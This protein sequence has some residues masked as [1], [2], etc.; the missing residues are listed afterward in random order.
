M[1]AT[2]LPQLALLAGAFTITF[3]APLV[4]AG[5]LGA[6]HWFRWRGRYLAALTALECLA[7]STLRCWQ[8]LP[9]V[10]AGQPYRLAYK[11]SERG[12]RAALPAG[13]ARMEGGSGPA[14]GW[15]RASQL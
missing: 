9:G 2:Y 13:S 12:R 8:W 6:E 3:A 7:Y 1:Q 10:A 5:L 14:A 4:V 15:G 11:A